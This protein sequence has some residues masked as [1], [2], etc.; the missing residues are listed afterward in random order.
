MR[1]RGIA[2]P[3][4]TGR[5]NFY[6][7]ILSI[8][9]VP[10]LP[11]PAG[12]VARG[13]ARSVCLWL[14]G[15]SG[16]SRGRP[17]RGAR[18]AAGIATPT[19]PRPPARSP[20]APA[21]CDTLIK[22]ARSAAHAGQGGSALSRPERAAE[23]GSCKHVDT[24]RVDT[25]RTLLTRRLGKLD[26]GPFGGVGDGV[27]DGGDPRVHLLGRLG[28]HE[29][30]EPTEQREAARDGLRLRRHV[31]VKHR[32][33]HVAED[34]RRGGTVLAPQVE[35]DLRRFLLRLLLARGVEVQPTVVE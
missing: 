8:G 16:G 18:R 5:F 22:L 14:L 7:N 25:F 30:L 32:Q 29:A 19:L 23:L 17:A 1:T 2:T 12:P 10:A 20:A 9:V 21:S 33:C 4:R 31:A 11:V 15:H 26:G 13:G 6:T 28:A 27:G 24:V 34:P 35:P 3:R